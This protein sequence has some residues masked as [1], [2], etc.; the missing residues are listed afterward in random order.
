MDSE[1]EWNFQKYLL[2]EKGQLI[3]T[4]RSPVS[5]FDELILSQ[6]ED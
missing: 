2:N 1:V 3:N 4:F 5:P 6:I